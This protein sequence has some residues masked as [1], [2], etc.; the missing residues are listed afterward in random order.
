VVDLRS[1]SARELNQLLRDEIREWR[2]ELDWDFAPTA[3]LVRRYAGTDSLNGAALLIQGEVAGY[4]YAVL[5]EP[6]GIIGDLYVR[7]GWRDS[8]LEVQLFRVLLEALAITP[9]VNRMESQLMLLS[10]GAA[11]LI[12]GVAAHGRTVRLFE[13]RLMVRDCMAK[14]LPGGDP[15]VRSGFRIERWDEHLL[16]AA[17]A[18]IACS[19]KDS[20][21]SEINLQYRSPAGARRFLFNIVEFPG[22]G[23]FHRA[24][25]FVAFDRETGEASGMVLSSFVSGDTGHVSQLCVTPQARGRGLGRE[26]LR[27]TVGELSTAGARCV[28]LTVTT[29]NA[30]AIS[31]Y[32]KI[33]FRRRRDFFAYTWEA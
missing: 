21:D 22:C 2:Q 28:S 29:A 1:V 15:D 7:P 10:P 17:A 4:G 18:I 30:P 12:A 16:H 25:S 20:P 19:Y 23:T 11:S 14:P 32:E 9:H 33:G 8:R 24:G 5:E 27:R 13:R 3:E 26:L 31:I 6:R